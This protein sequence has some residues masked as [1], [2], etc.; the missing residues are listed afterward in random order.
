MQALICHQ[1]GPIEC[2]SLEEVASPTVQ[3]NQVLVKVMAASVN[4]PDA[5]IVQGLY[6]MKPAF[7]F[8]PGAELAGE[9][10]QVAPNVKD[11]QVGDR[12]IASS[13]YG[14]FAQECLVDASKLMPLPE[15]MS[16]ELGSAFV[17]TY[18]TS[19][20]ALK[21]CAQ[22]QP[23]ETVLILGAAGGVGIAAIEIAKQM[24]AI[25]IAAASS[26][27]KRELCLEVGADHA[28]DYTQTDWRKQVEA[29]TAGRGVDVVYDAV[30]GPYSEIALRATAWRGRYL[31][32]GFA[33]GEIPKIP[34]NL[35]LLGERKILGVFWGQAVRTYPEVHKANMSILLDWFTQGKIKPAITQRVTLN[36]A[37]QAIQDLAD[38]KVQGKIVVLPN[39]T[40]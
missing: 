20:H 6:Q 1:F 22:L 2:L 33:A 9:I 18:G 10:I 19:L 31:V 13:G 35:A 27:A 38:R 7:P 16:Y 23:G 17:L 21:E 39:S 12:V 29:L 26:E 24:G 8:S 25:V 4:F 34:L 5:L 11:W 14:A 28:I 30:G 36:Q 15:V 3:D 40:S 37:K 32:V